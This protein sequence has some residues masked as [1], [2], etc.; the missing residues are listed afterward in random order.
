MRTP[1]ESKPRPLSVS[2][3]RFS[4]AIAVCATMLAAARGAT[5]SWDSDALGTNNAASGAGLGGSGI[6]DTSAPAKWWS[7]GNTDVLWNNAGNDTAVFDGLAGTVNLGAPVTVQNLVFRTPGYVLTGSVANSL[8]LAPKAIINLNSRDGSAAD[9]TLSARLVGDGPTGITLNGNGGTLMLNYAGTHGVTGPLTI[10]SGT[11]QVNGAVS[12]LDAGTGVTFKGSGTFSLDNVG[13]TG[14]T[15]YSLGALTNTG[16]DGVVHL[17]RTETQNV[18]L[19][20]ASLGARSPGATGVFEANGNTANLSTNAQI[21]VAGVTANS[22]MTGY[23][24]RS[25]GGFGRFAWN[26]AAGFVRELIYQGDPGTQTSGATT[27]VLQ[28]ANNHWQ[29]TGTLSGQTTAAILSLALSG[30]PNLFLANNALLTVT[31]AGD[32]GSILKTGG[33]SSTISLASGTGG[34]TAGSARELIIRTDAANDTLTIS[35]PITGTTGA[36]TKSGAGTLILSGTNAFTGTTYVN[37]GKLSIR[38]SAAAGAAGSTEVSLAGGTYELLGYGANNNTAETI[39]TGKNVTLT[40]SAILTAGRINPTTDAATNKTLAFGNLNIGNQIL[41]ADPAVY[42]AG[43]NPPFAG[44]YALSFTGTT[45]FTDALRPTFNVTGT[46]ASGATP[47]LTLAGLVIQEPTLPG[48]VTVGL[49]KRGTGTLALGNAGNTFGGAGAVVELQGGVLSIAADGALGDAANS[50]LLNASETTDG[51]LITDNIVSS[52]DVALGQVINNIEVA[53]TKTLTLNG[54]VTSNIAAGLAKRGTG[55][56]VLSNTSNTFGGSGGVIDI[57]GGTLQT[58]TSGALGSVGN[59]VQLNGGIFGVPVSAASFTAAQNFNVALSSGTIDLASPNTLTISGRISSSSSV[60]NLTKTGPGSLTLTNAGN[61][62]GGLGSTL[63]IQGGGTLTVTSGGALGDPGNAVKLSGNFVGNGTSTASQSFIL[64]QASNANFD[65]PGSN[66][67]TIAGVASNVAAVDF[68]KTGSGT[69]NLTG[70][71]TFGGSK[72]IDITGGFLGA[73]SDSSLGQTTNTLRLNGGGFRALGTFS[74]GS[75]PVVLAGAS[76]EIAVAQGNALTIGSAFGVAPLANALVKSDLGTLVL[77]VA[78]PT[79]TGG[80]TINAGA[81]RVSGSAANALGA[82]STGTVI[83]GIGGLELTASASVAEPLTINTPGD[84]TTM[85]GSGFGGVLRAIGTGTTSAYTGAITVNAAQTDNTFRSIVIGAD[86]GT[87]FTLSS[88]SSIGFNNGVGGTGRVANLILAGDSVNANT[89]ASAVT[90]TTGAVNLVKTGAGNWVLAP[91]AVPQVDGITVRSG[92]LQSN[93]NATG[94]LPSTTTLTFTGSSTFLHNNVGSFATLNRSLGALTFSAG[95]GTVQNERASNFTS[96]LTFASPLTRQTG[97]TGRFWVNNNGAAFATSA[98]IT[99]TG[100]TANTF[101]GAGYFAQANATTTGFAW[102]DTGSFVRT[103][104]Y[105]TD[106]GATI[107]SGNLTASKHNQTTG[108]GAIGLAASTDVLSLNIAGTNTLTVGAGQV[109]TIN[110]GGNSGGLLKT[111]GAGSI[112]GAGMLTAGGAGNELVVRTDLLADA[113]TIS[114]PITNTGA[115]TKSGLG[116]L[117]LSGTQSWTGGTFVNGGGL[118]LQGVSALGGGTAL[119]LSGGTFSLQADGDLRGS[120]ENIDTSK[121]VTVDG[122]NSGI[123]VGKLT[124]A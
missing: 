1:R 12:T 89:L 109:L 121:N 62:F 28:N 112:G 7:G 23:F 96:T 87:T 94:V 6:W 52:R 123:T 46:Q 16:G 55:T 92:T 48:G 78:Q 60:A 39:T 90:K 85:S 104:N 35:A 77:T 72:L 13:A 98:K 45:T 8:T 99:L 73:A 3:A 68:T 111:G 86:A 21:S 29:L 76:N 65:V 31:N 88:A 4:S 101:L 9:T 33:G 119:S 81:I 82:T 107:A 41:T 49:I 5:F 74:T 103:L 54:L 53:A 69:L 105:A 106:N 25:E 27:S 84:N 14:T 122:A 91:T 83:G 32:A 71:N 100:A 108:S 20:F 75:R 102:Y 70:V 56:L 95:D 42:A 47:A 93:A 59:T 124:A 50:L 58:S 51:L 26:D 43:A 30:A 67:F 22:F 10:R 24:A 117:T 114:I 11:L 116:T 64:A 40:G 97:A 110:A 36:V 18:Q 37:G 66:V 61:T 44:V 15:S 2:L 17:E 19:S 115:L 63:D 38:G 57:Q 118:I 79:W 120:M 80:I 113:L 34:V